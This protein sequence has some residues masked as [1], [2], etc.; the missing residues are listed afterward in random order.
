MWYHIDYDEVLPCA[1]CYSCKR[2]FCGCAHRIP[3]FSDRN[4]VKIGVVSLASFEGVFIVEQLLQKMKS[5]LLNLYRGRHILKTMVIKDMKSKYTGSLFG[6]FWMFAAPLYQI[7]L[8]TFIFSLILKV[9][10]EEGMGTSSFVIYFLAGLIPW[11]FFAETTSRGVSVF[12]ENAHI[13]KKVKI[14]MEVCVAS[15]L[16]SSSVTF[17]IYAVFYLTMLILMGTLKLPVFPLVIFPFTIQV[18]LTLGLCFGLGSIAVFFRDLT[19]AI[20]MILNLGFFLTPIVYP[21]SAIPERFRWV[22]DINPF[23]FIV[24]IYRDILIRG[25]FPDAVSF[26]YPFV[27]S[28]AVF[29]S[30]YYVFN[31]TK[32]AFKDIL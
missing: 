32:G 8:Y 5:L 7:L 1:V 20:G 2:I 28:L 31:K 16:V 23:Y 29:F 17:F 22:F 18:L 10:F 24:E 4:A 21:S 13:I 30:G 9:R 26:M 25:K 6:P 3:S 15:L 11:T 14:P 19:Q 27:F 12:I